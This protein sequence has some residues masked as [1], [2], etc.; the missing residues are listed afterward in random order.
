MF[1]LSELAV[2]LIVVIALILARKGP[3]LARNAGKSARI[4]KAEA[5]AMK[6]AE[7]EEAQA[8]GTDASPDHQGRPLRARER[9]QPARNGRPPTRTASRRRAAGRR[10]A[11]RASGSPSEG[12]RSSWN[13]TISAT[14]LP[15]TRRTSTVRGRWAPVRSRRR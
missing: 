7:Q 14:A 5:Q 6:R 4:L 8:R 13:V 9:P 12:N 11:Y 1:G 3:E 15:T 10:P 2:I